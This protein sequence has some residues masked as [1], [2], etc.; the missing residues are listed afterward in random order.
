MKNIRRTI[1]L[2]FFMYYGL[3]GVLIGIL[4]IVIGHT[5]FQAI[6]IGKEIFNSIGTTF[7]VGSL[8]GLLYT[9]LSRNI[10]YDELRFLIDRE[11]SGFREI[12]AKSDD[13]AFTDELVG[14]IE[15]SKEIKMYGIAI[16]VLWRPEVVKQIK[17]AALKRR[18]KTTILLADTTSSLIQDRLV[19]EEDFPFP[20]TQ[21]KEIISNLY[22][23]LKVIET[24]INDLDYFS[25]RKFSH[26][27]TFTLII[28]DDDIYCYPYGFKTIGSVSPVTHLKGTT[29]PANYY[30]EQFD[31]LLKHY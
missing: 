25:V 2:L 31:L 26:Y 3:I 11:E 28:A 4:L 5:V 21:G 22:D 7:V 20:N 9:N 23:R 1:D 6:D 15:V 16:N 19:E 13:S 12:F 10:Y 30:H 18:T 17:E 27:P 14:K 24:E 29:A 8:F